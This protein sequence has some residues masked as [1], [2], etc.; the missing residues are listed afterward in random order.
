[1]QNVSSPIKSILKKDA[2][3]TTIISFNIIIKYNMFKVYA[4]VCFSN[5]VV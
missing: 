1:M 2:E 4:A 3:Y 5:E